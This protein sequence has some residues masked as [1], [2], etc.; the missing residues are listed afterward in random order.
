MSEWIDAYKKL[1]ADETPV[2]VIYRG[3]YR[4]GALY[5]EEGDWE[6]G[7]PSFRYWDDAYDDGQDWEFHDVEFWM[8]LP[9]TPPP[10]T[11]EEI[12]AFYSASE[13]NSEN[14]DFVELMPVPGE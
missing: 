1:P 11:D 10:K 2:L 9:Q 6:S 4:I 5:W 3:E 12:E 7:H 13:K 8:P 14:F